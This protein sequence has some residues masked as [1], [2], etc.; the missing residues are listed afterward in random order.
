MRS[1][2]IGAN[3]IRNDGREPVAG[4]FT[5][6]VVMQPEYQHC[7]DSVVH[8]PHLSSIHPQ[9]QL[10]VIKFVGAGGN[11]RPVDNQCLHFPLPTETA[12]VPGTVVGLAHLSEDAVY[13]DVIHANLEFG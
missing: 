5:L 13:V 4:C 12:V 8:L 7:L 1:N 2:L 10:S 6:R 3:P 9:I 11:R